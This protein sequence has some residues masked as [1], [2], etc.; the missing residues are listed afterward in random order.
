MNNN[1]EFIRCE[2]IHPNTI[3]SSTKKTP[4]KKTDNTS[5]TSAKKTKKMT[6]PDTTINTATVMPV[7]ADNA[8]N[9]TEK[10]DKT[11]ATTT[12]VATATTTGTVLSEDSDYNYTL[13]K[14]VPEMKS[15]LV[16]I[17]YVQHRNTVKLSDIKEV[18]MRVSEKYLKIGIDIL[19]QQGVIALPADGGGRSRVVTYDIVNLPMPEELMPVT[20]SVPETT[21]TTA[22][23]EGS[24]SVQKKV[25]KERR[26]SGGSSSIGEGEKEKKVKKVSRKRRSNGQSIVV[27]VKKT[28][29]VVDSEGNPTSTTIMEG[30][31]GQEQPQY[32]DDFYYGEDSDE[33]EENES[34]LED[35]EQE[36]E[37]ERDRMETVKRVK[38]Q[39]RLI[40]I[41]L[42]SSGFIG[43]SS[44]VEV[45]EM[46]LTAVPSTNDVA[47][48]AAVK[49]SV[50]IVPIA[51]ASKSILPK[52][53]TAAPKASE[54]P[55]LIASISEMLTNEEEMFSLSD[56]I[57]RFINANNSFSNDVIREVLEGFAAK[58]HIMIA[59]D[60]VYKI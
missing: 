7:V 25:K 53:P 36:E 57:T 55:H 27:P 31:E 14:I 12:T 46:L 49:E 17:R 23:E 48:I 43:H 9:A 33:D 3:T 4:V 32:E 37:D 5:I 1:N 42:H 60:D 26:E 58:N 44:N 15:V 28:M 8:N 59:D 56:F 30:A 16:K 21:A 24:M 39:D 6:A 41:P 38:K 22:N 40:T 29:T 54:D 19:L 2:N 13:E 35:S 52:V 34:L 10:T 47:S 51:P 11:V 20:V 18:L 50:T 45:T